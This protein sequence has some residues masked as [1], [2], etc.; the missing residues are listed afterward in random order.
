[1]GGQTFLRQITCY[2]ESPPFR[3]PAVSF[4]TKYRFTILSYNNSKFSLICQAPFPYRDFN[5]ISVFLLVFRLKPYPTCVATV[6][7][8]LRVKEVPCFLAIA[9]YPLAFFLLCIACNH[10]PESSTFILAA[11]II[12]KSQEKKD[13]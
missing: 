6:R 10:A 2:A 8:L 5:C 3:K 7:S 9:W 11:L 4:G 13:L 12:D 1:M